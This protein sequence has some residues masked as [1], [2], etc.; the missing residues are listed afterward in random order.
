MQEYICTRVV[1]LHG[2]RIGLT[3]EQ[4]DPRSRNL[5]PV[6]GRK[7]VYEVVSSVQFKAGETIQM[8]SP[9]KA[10]LTKVEKTKDSAKPET[11]KPDTGE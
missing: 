4:A 3:K 9:D 10:V 1:D 2:G 11:K 8:E 5:R 6:K 7:G